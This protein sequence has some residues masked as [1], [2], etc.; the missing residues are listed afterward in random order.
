MEKKILIT[1]DGSIHSNNALAYAADLYKSGSEVS[2][3]LLN[4]QPMVSQYL[5]DDA[6]TDMEARVALDK[7]I[8]RHLESSEELL[9]AC[10][11]R[12]CD[13]GI[14]PDRIT[15]ASRKRLP[16]QARSIIE[17]A[18]QDHYSALVIGRRGLTR[19]QK[20]FMG[21][22]SAKIM[23]HAG[24]I[25]LWI[26]DGNIKLSNAL[27]ALDASDHSMHIIDYLA[28]TIGDV[29]GVDLCFFHVQQ[30]PEDALLID[31]EVNPSLA[32]IIQ[33]SEEKWTNQFWPEAV[34]R[35]TAGGIHPDRIK[36]VTLQRKGR[37]AKAILEQIETGNFDTVILGRS[38]SGQSF[39]FGRVSRYV[40]ERLTD[41]AVWLIG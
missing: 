41:R 11:Q 9:L 12:L 8:Q 36:L 4:I 23:D 10:K 15:T 14:A 5:L 18:N 39:Y 37:V 1:V 26:I 2:Y 29:P 16:G 13:L 24:G 35:L 19:M 6:R 32:R 22:T 28:M 33:R 20:I 38:G 21:S 40:A 34:K 17:F 7:L 31:E 3:T 30:A 27:V 25:P